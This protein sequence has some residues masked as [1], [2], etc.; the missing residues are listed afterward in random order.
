MNANDMRKL[1][2]DVGSENTFDSIYD[3]NQMF[4]GVLNESI[5]IDMSSEVYRNKM[6]ELMESGLS[7][8]QAKMKIIMEA[9]EDDWDEEDYDDL[10]DEEDEDS[11]E[12]EYTDEYEGS[13]SEDESE[14]ES[15]WGSSESAK[16]E[17]E[18]KESDKEKRTK[19]RSEKIKKP[20]KKKSMLG[21][22]KDT[23]DDTSFSKS[24][25]QGQG[26]SSSGYEGSKPKRE[27]QRTKGSGA[28]KGVGKKRQ[29]EYGK[30]E[31]IEDFKGL[32]T[33][34][35]KE[36]TSGMTDYKRGQ[37][38]AKAE[39]DIL[40][41]E[42]TSRYKSPETASKYG[43]DVDFE[44]AMKDAGRSLGRQQSTDVK[45]SSDEELADY[46]AQR[47]K[48][49][50]SSGKLP[51]VSAKEISDTDMAP[52]PAGI[53]AGEREAEITRQRGLEK[54]LPPEEISKQMKSTQRHASLG[55]EDPR[56]TSTRFLGQFAGTDK[57]TDMAKREEEAV[58]LVQSIQQG[59]NSNETISN[60]ISLFSK[61]IQNIIRGASKGS[62]NPD[63]V[64]SHISGETYELARD[65][66]PEK[67]PN[68]SSYYL[69]RLRRDAK[70]IGQRLSRAESMPSS[71]IRT[72]S[73][74]MNAVKKAKAEL[75]R[76]GEPT[77]R[78]VMMRAAELAGY[79]DNVEAFVKQ[80][81]KQSSLTSKNVDVSTAG[82]K[83][84]ETTSFDIEGD[85]SPEEEVGFK[86]ERHEMDAEEARDIM[87]NY[88]STMPEDTK[89]VISMYLGLDDGTAES[90]ISSIDK[91]LGTRKAYNILKNPKGSFH[92][93][94]GNPD[95][96]EASRIW[97]EDQ[98]ATTRA[99]SDMA[100]SVDVR[101]RERKR[102][103]I[104][105]TK[106]E[107]GQVD[108]ESIEANVQ[109]ARRGFVSSIA[110]WHPASEVGSKIKS[111]LSSQV[112]SASEEELMAMVKQIQAGLESQAKA[113]KIP[114]EDYKSFTRIANAAKS[115]GRQE[116]AES[117]DD[118]VLNR[119]MECASY[120]FGKL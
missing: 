28:T 11:D 92:I 17:K 73:K 89:K 106:D 119:I 118:P 67:V 34:G 22:E 99:E 21:K 60:L 32:K 100:S 49:Q 69:M 51:G 104:D 36:T 97:L 57:D 80:L 40:K 77:N 39:R 82:M 112:G 10:Y 96:E 42:R 2:D 76:T 3:E 31:N 78:E 110:N 79:E 64:W 23:S 24:E 101:G 68:F 86:G 116:V 41:P 55:V 113:G 105:Y 62:V 88:L 30:D 56:D 4:N 18:Q 19:A 72:G 117:E 74:I 37:K 63:D 94:M 7:P 33:P 43:S 71:S 50:S 16:A 15:E 84:D 120:K 53:G 52:R 47:D 48:N 85:V 38:T 75:S 108:P 83:D 6:L 46:Q 12:K 91:K 29:A 98:A 70:D 111:I 66:D 103:V 1:L 81:S 90:N 9:E 25:Y 45:F 107:E 20:S 13:D 102:D 59:D 44:K 5:D 54:E 95:F 58:P 27:V 87:M 114:N 14:A 109:A 115:V 35:G 8:A 61:E 65:W 26:T 93:L